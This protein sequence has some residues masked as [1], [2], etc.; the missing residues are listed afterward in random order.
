MNKTYRASLT[1]ML[2]PYLLGAVVLIGL[3][4][5]LTLALSFFRYDG[6]SAPVWVGG[7]NYRVALANPVDVL[8]PISISNTLYFVVFAVPVRLLGALSLALWLNRRGQGV[9]LYRAAVYLPTIIPDVAYALIWMW[10]FNPLYGPLNLILNAIGLHTPG[11]LAD[12]KYAK[13]VF[14][15]MTAFQIGEGFVVLLAGLQNIPREYYASAAIDGGNA[16]QQFRHITLP[17]LAPWLFLLALR[18][19]IFSSQN[20]FTAN[21]IMTG[22]DPYYSTLF[23]PL[24]IYEEAFDRMRF[25]PGA[26]MTVLLGL[27]TAALIGLALSIVGNW[28]ESDAD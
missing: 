22:G 18:D 3:P 13:V 5:L 7:F 4:A 24:L 28:G 14:V 8:F 12:A 16:W 11:W 21:L 6:V 26:A 15:T 19:T 9:G 1:L 17:L 27:V 10:V 25:G 2:A 23:A 20:M